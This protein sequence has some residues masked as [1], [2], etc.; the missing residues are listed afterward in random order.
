MR[1][2]IELLK[3]DIVSEMGKL[4]KLYQEFAPMAE[5]LALSEDDVG[6]HDMIVLGYLMHNFYN[7]CENMFRSIARFFENEM[8]ADSW[9]KDLLRRMTFEIEGF[10][11]RVIS[12]QLYLLLDDFRGFRHKFRYTYSFELDWERE[13]V[14]AR[15]FKKAWA[16]LQDEM[17]VFMGKLEKIPEELQND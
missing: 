3:A 7:G 6:K 14:V 12:D 9:H 10:R 4:G 1:A 13:K 15:K 17:G 5:K 8:D 16:L 2:D 11:P